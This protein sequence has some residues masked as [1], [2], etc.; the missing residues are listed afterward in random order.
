MQT[1]SGTNSIDLLSPTKSSKTSAKSSKQSDGDD[2]LS[3]VLNAAQSKTKTGEKLS[4]DDVKDIVKSVGM[5][6]EQGEIAREESMVKIANE[7]ASK[8]DEA[9]KNELYENANFM[10]LLQVLDIINGGERL[11]KYPDFSDKIASFLS[12]SENV[13]ELSKVGNVNDLIELAKKFDLGLE[14]ISITQEDIANLDEMFKNLAK[15]DFF[16][17]VLPENVTKFSQNLKHQV[18]QAITEQG[19]TEQNKLGEILNQV[20]KPVQNAVAAQ[21]ATTEQVAKEVVATNLKNQTKTVTQTPSQTPVILGDEEVAQPVLQDAKIPQVLDDENL[22]LD[23]NIKEPKEQKVSLKALVFPEQENNEEVMVS[24]LGEVTQDAGESENSELNLLVRDIAKNAQSQLNARLTSRTLSNFS[25]DL[26]Q[27]IE[28]YKAPFT[29]V[30]MTLNPL[31]LGEVEVSM[32]TRG[33]NLHVN[34]NSTTATMNLFLQNQAE[35]KANLINMGFTELEMNFS[36]Q[37]DSQNQNR[38]GFK[39]FTSKF[40]ENG[41]F[42]ADEEPVTLE[43]ILPRYA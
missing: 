9:T 40:N 4:E 36:N 2:F 3:M 10:Q 26:A 23:P 39:N 30:N 12:K 33:N 17:P 6:V 32:V 1:Y 13:I 19:T 11:S 25:Q 7:I 27:Q 34:F 5:Q 41:E 8:L 16:T 14:N 15:K 20:T 18:E 42:L 24:N 35:F 28:N 21:V 43:L 38:Q 31:N 37:R 29:R 22:K